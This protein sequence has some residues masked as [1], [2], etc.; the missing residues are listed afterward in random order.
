MRIST[1]PAILSVAI[2]ISSYA[3]AYRYDENKVYARDPHYV[4]TLSHEITVRDLLSE[5]TTR[6]LV[7]ELD[8]RG[9]PLDNTWSRT[10]AKY[11]CTSCNMKFDSESKM[12]EYA[13]MRLLVIP[14]MP[15]C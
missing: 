5:L 10:P 14:K 4:D 15:G 12:S 2:F 11:P 1:F 9:L 7:D 3:N 13:C 8:R 6:E